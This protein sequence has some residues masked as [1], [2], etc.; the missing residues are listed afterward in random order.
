MTELNV[1]NG[2]A[3]LIRAKQVSK[4]FQD[5]KSSNDSAGYVKA[6]DGVDLGVR[7]EEIVTIVGP[8][9][10]GKLHCS[11]SSPDLKA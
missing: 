4:V 11:I 5:Q 7:K 1:L 9:G 6:L 8:S 10:C 3:Y 2:D